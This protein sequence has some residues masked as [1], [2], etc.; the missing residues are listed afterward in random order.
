MKTNLKSVIAIACMAQLFFSCKKDKIDNPEIP[1]E[2]IVAGSDNGVANVWKNGIA[3][4]ISTASAS[5]AKAIAVSGNDV[6]ATGYENTPG[7]WRGKVWKNG[8]LLHSMGESGFPTVGYGIAVANNN[9]YV[10]G[11]GYNS[12][13]FEH[14]AILWTN[15]T[16]A[17]LTDGLEQAEAFGVTVYGSDV[18]VAG[19]Y[20]NEARLW[21]NGVIVPIAN[22][23]GYH[24]ISVTVVG[25]DV[26][27]LGNL[28][29]VTGRIK[30]WK[31]GNE[32]NIT[33]GSFSAMGTSLIVSGTDVFI[34]GA[35]A[36]AAN[37]YVAKIWKNG[38]PVSLSDGTKSA[39][40]YGVA[41]KGTDVYV[42][43]VENST[44][45]GG[46][47]NAMFWK[48]GVR[49]V[50]SSNSSNATAIFVR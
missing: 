22:G 35:E 1:A 2:V 4:A 18:Y 46:I 14:Y 48:N 39:W 6:Y 21:K 30:Y 8:A 13:S 33:D 19:Y 40:A 45:A 28:N 9:V 43:G 20:G 25:N 34:S 24:A 49:T 42:A 36:N 44:T 47:Q 7:G 38:N 32:I 29:A 41:V 50:L 15:D 12:F 23:T 26:Y 17:F 10:A 31:N 37:K 5:Y 3:S 16:P 27:V 11:H